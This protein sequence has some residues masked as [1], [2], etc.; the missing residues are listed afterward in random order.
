MKIA[1]LTDLHANREALEAVLQHAAIAG[2]ERFVVEIF[3]AKDD[4]FLGPITIAQTISLCL[5]AFGIWGMA[6]LRAAPASSG[7]P[8]KAA[9]RAAQT[10]REKRRARA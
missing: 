8:K 7:D 9:A 4:R 5:I 10:R 2:A 3:R 1:L 6:R